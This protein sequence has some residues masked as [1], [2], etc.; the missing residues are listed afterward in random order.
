M[1]NKI[2]YAVLGCLLMSC[3]IVRGQ[4]QEGLVQLDKIDFDKIV[5][6]FDYSLVKFD[7]SYPTGVKHKNFGKIASEVNL[8]W[9]LDVVV[10]RY[11]YGRSYRQHTW[12]ENYRL[13][14]K[15]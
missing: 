9:Q 8:V 13:V 14:V 6:K 11:G 1:A 2:L 5:S 10:Q 15:R 12:F 7:T 4:T 3:A